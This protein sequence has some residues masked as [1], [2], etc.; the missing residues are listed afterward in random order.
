MVILE[1]IARLS[2][3]IFQDTHTKEEN[4]A[5]AYIINMLTAVLIQKITIDDF[6]DYME[7]AP[8]CTR[9]FYYNLLFEDK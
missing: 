8:Q 5:L 9:E 2:H 4:I 6:H 7:Y 1:E 3:T